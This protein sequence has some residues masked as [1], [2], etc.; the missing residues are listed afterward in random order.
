[1][2]FFWVYMF[3]WKKGKEIQG[4]ILLEVAFKHLCDEYD[5]SYVF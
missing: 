3:I 1:M 2:L 4:V 5:F